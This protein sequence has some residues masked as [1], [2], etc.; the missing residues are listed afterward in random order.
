MADQMQQTA[1]HAASTGQSYTESRFLDAH[2]EMCRPEYE[3]MLRSAGIQQG[4][5]VLD[6]GCGGGS[7]LPLI[8]DLVWPGGG[9]AALDL[10]PDNIAVVEGRIGEWLLPCPVRAQ[11]GTVTA[12]P[13][14]DDSFD[15]VWCA[16]TTQYLS[17][18]ELTAMLAECWRVVRPGGLVAIKEFDAACHR[19]AP[20]DPLLMARMYDAV[21]AVWDGARG[22]LRARDLHAWLTRAGL[23]DARQRTTLVE[24]RAPL[25]PFEQRL[26]A[27]VSAGYAKRALELSL[28]AEDTAF[29]RTML[30]PDAPDNPVNGPDYYFCEGDVVALGRVPV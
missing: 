2:F 15:A 17:D 9:I 26:L 27:D 30:D 22:S 14:A 24:R 29:W 3:A 18:E 10:A 21:R 28:S 1:P 16:N 19:M 7:F 12:L 4:W 8:A 25:R 20:G 13:Y 23:V 5:Q 6:A 11:V